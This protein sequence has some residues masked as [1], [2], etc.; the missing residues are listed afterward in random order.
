MNLDRKTER[1]AERGYS[2]VELM[3][4]IVIS[5][6]ITA[7]I[8]AAYISQQRSFVAQDQ[9]TEMNSTSRISLD[10]I[11]NDIRE[12]G[13]GLPD[14][15]GFDVNGFT[16]VLT[17]TDNND[18]PD[19]LTI[20]GSFRRAG[21]LCSNI[22]GAEIDPDDRILNIVLTPGREDQSYINTTD[23]SNISLAGI[24]YAKVTNVVETAEGIQVTLQ[25]AVGV[26]FPRYTDADGDAV[27]DDGEGVPVYLVEDYTY[28]VVNGQL[29]RV[30]RINSVDSDVDVIAENIEDLQ[31][32]LNANNDLVRVNILAST[33]RPD[34]NFR[35]LGNPPATIENRDFEATNDGL[36]RRWWQ[37]EVSG[38][39][40]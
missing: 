37:M 3:V 24:A 26:A 35:G 1:L 27:C 11:A 8:Y 4:V 19:E 7:S 32:V 23:R 9:V 30:R 22:G 10:L 12:A 40:L 17:L 25:D 20:V 13:F 14:S 6:I 39:N 15:G 16:Q 31:I 29:Q 34:P 38:R 18:G 33:A 36:R 2:L 28:R 5:M 21:T